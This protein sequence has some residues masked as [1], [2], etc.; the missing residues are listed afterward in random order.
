MMP[1]ISGMDLYAK[2]AQRRPGLERRMIFMTGGAFTQQARNFLES[3]P[4]KWLEKP[5]EIRQVQDLVK[6]RIAA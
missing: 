5:F 2:T 3:V 6:K 1:D 4:N